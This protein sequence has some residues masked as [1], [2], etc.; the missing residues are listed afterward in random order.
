MTSVP[1]NNAVS[2]AGWYADPEADSMLR[3]WNGTAWTEDRQAAQPAAPVGIPINLPAPASATVVSDA[4]AAASAPA[5]F[6]SKV[7][8]A[9]N[10]PQTQGAAVG[11][12][13]AG[14]IAGGAAA[15]TGVGA[16]RA[17]RKVKIGMI[18]GFVG[19]LGII[20]G[21]SQAMFGGSTSTTSPL[22]GGLI[23]IL[24]GFAVVS[25]GVASLA[26]RVG[27]LGGGLMLLRN[28]WKK[29]SGPAAAAQ[30]ESAPEN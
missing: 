1:E 27:T 5:S 23:L 10:S 28:G 4:E 11:A 14:L 25:W 3:W 7:S 15:L 12:L 20:G 13:G 8:G 26:I 30:T 24:I 29:A 6:G 16:R 9:L 18:I 22:P 2:P 17:I 21:V 19:L